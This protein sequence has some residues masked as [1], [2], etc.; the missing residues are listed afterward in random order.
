ME[1]HHKKIEKESMYYQHLKDEKYFS[2]LKETSKFGDK[3]SI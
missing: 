1:L 3:N 2:I